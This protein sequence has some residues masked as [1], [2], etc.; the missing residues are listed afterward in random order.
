MLSTLFAPLTYTIAALLHIVNATM[1]RVPTLPTLPHL[2]ARRTPTNPPTPS[3]PSLL[4]PSVERSLA[5]L[6]HNAPNCAGCW[7][8]LVSPNTLSSLTNI[9]WQSRGAR[10]DVDIALCPARAPDRLH[11]VRGQGVIQAPASLVLSLVEGVHT[12]QQWEPAYRDG[13]V[14]RDVVDAH[15]N[16]RTQLLWSRHAAGEF[17][18]L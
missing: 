18:L 7:E 17:L 4:P 16:V 5:F 6:L 11:K 3:P 13:E 8:H 15:T 9:T 12:V 2:Q 10:N 1:A 14:L